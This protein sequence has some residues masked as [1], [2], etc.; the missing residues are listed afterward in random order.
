[1]EDGNG[2]VVQLRGANIS[3]LEGGI[4]WSGGTQYWA[5]AGLGTRPD[6]TKLAAW[7]MNAVRLPLNEDSW[8]GKTVT[9]QMGD[10]FALNGAGYQAEVAASVAA[11]NAAGL[12]VILDLHW[13]APA[14]FAANGQN[15]MGNADNTVAFWTGVAQAFKG[16]PAVMFE[17]FNEPYLGTTAGNGVS[18]N[19]FTALP[20]GANYYIRNG[21]AQAFCYQTEGT[22]GS[23]IL[24]NYSWTQVGY[25]QLLN[26]VRA[27]GATNVIIMGGQGYDNDETWWTTNPPT[28]TLSPPQIAINYHAYPTTWGYEMTGTST[29]YTAAVSQA[30]L[31]TPGVPVF[32]TEMG[33]PTGSGADTSWNSNLLKVIDSLGWNVFAWTWNPWGGGANVLITDASTYTPTPGLGA[34]YYNWVYNHA[35]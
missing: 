30:M 9:D 4:I 8:L 21:G 27:T 18:P 23:E 32:I 34:T 31:I 11:A 10:K 26:A 6:F 20:N 1:L 19:C 2:K 33:G 3:G 12:Y 7:K 35:Q 24:V 14:N 29:Q 22:G 5:S 28:D 15:P 16:N 13:T 25:Q 17:L